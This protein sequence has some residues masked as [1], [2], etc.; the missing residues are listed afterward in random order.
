M[1]YNYK[2]YELP[3]YG[4][5]EYHVVVD[6]FFKQIIDHMTIPNYVPIMQSDDKST[7]DTIIYTGKENLAGDWLI[8]KVIDDNTG[9][10]ASSWATIANNA[11]YST[12]TSAFTNRASL[13]YESD[14][15]N[16]I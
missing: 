7:S 4:D 13:N 2:L 8:K 6:P 16:I 1:S 9:I 14:Y 5:K 11:S 15:N 12:L 3:S 10:Y